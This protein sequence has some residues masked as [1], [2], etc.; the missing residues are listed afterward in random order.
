MRMQMAKLT[1]EQTQHLRNRLKFMSE[2]VGGVLS[3]A[4]G[5]S[6]T[7]VIVMVI[8]RLASWW[9]ATFGLSLRIRHVF[10][11]EQVGFKRDFIS[12]HFKPEALFENMQDI[13]TSS[14][15]RDLIS[16]EIKPI[17][18]SN[19]W[20]CGIECDTLSGLNG[21]SQVGKAVT[22]SGD[23]KTGSTAKECMGY[24]RRA[25]PAIIVLENIK[26]LAAASSNTAVKSTDLEILVKQLNEMHY[27]VLYK[28]LNASDF[29]IPQRR[30]RWY[31]LGFYLG[32]DQ[33]VDQ[34]VKDFDSSTLPAFWHQ[35]AQWLTEMQ[36]DT[37]PF[38]SFLL[39]HDDVRVNVWP[40]IV[41]STQP[42]GKKD[43]G[44]KTDKVLEFVVD[45][46][47]AFEQ[48]ELTHPP[49]FTAEF[50][51]RTEHLCVRKKELVWFHEQLLRREA[52]AS[53]SQ[54]SVMDANMT[55]GWARVCPGVCPCLVGS[56]HMW[57]F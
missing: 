41:P 15:A 19:I 9:T 57:L 46:I 21:S 5:C 14:S 30:L 47:Q 18:S 6:G 3:I 8:Q 39:P 56:S 36:I 12:A 50:D 13:G 33:M 37:L 16:G 20:A 24:I 1:I 48:N 28:V 32:P 34:T 10:S 2:A 52:D 17:Q 53:P 22:L 4:T 55:I 38:E 35:A 45:H 11:C 27:M 29:G 25:R 43:K 31:L 7:D 40:T 49:C 54:V 44:V 26:N 23:G 51:Q 42:T